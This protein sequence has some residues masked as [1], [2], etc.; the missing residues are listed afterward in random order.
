[1]DLKTPKLAIA[2][3]ALT[4]MLGVSYYFIEY[5]T[6]GSPR[7]SRAL[8]AEFSYLERFFQDEPEESLTSMA[9]STSIVKV[10]III[11][12]SVRP[13]IPGESVMQDR[14]DITPELFEQQ[15]IYIRDHGYTTISPDALVLDI[16]AGTTTPTIKPVMLTFDDGWENQYKYAFPLLEK[17]HMTATFYVYTKPIDNNKLSYLSWDQLREVDAAGMTIG[18]HTLTHPLLKRL[19]TADIQNEIVMS[20]KIIEG[21]L[22]KPVFHFAQPFGYSSSEI[23]KIIMNAGYRTARGTYRGVYHSDADIFNLQGY[24][25]SDTFGEF[26]HILNRR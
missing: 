24:F 16:K 9:T 10:P 12:H 26:V 14:F 5:R 17:Y 23:E 3:A 22:K 20:K 8:T 1:M 21:E 7:L 11:Y 13:Y 2:I 25:V 6:F 18:S 19:A 15:L 4:L